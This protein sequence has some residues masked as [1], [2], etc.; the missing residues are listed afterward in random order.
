MGNNF[1][2]GTFNQE[3]GFLPKYDHSFQ[4]HT[5]Y[6]YVR[7]KRRIDEQ[8]AND[9]DALIDKK[10]PFADRKYHARPEL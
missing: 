6:A 9:T 10:K 8:I 4:K 5:L 3:N 7:G 2:L 1:V